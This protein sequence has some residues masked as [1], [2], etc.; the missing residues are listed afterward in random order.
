MGVGRS[1][2][3]PAEGGAPLPG[4]RVFSVPALSWDAGG[5]GVV[6]VRLLPRG[7]WEAL[8]GPDS[9]AARSHCPRGRSTLCVSRTRSGL[10][11]R[12]EAVLLP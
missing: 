1:L 9:V 5:R 11:S 4:W 8:G 7:A 10:Q 12:Q 2:C 3:V 6:L